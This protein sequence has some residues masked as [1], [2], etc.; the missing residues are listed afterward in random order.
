MRVRLPTQ[1]I[2]ILVL[3]AAGCASERRYPPPDPSEAE[4]LVEVGPVPG[5]ESRI[6]QASAVDVA[7]RPRDIL[8]LSGGGMYGA[9]PAGVLKGWAASGK[10]PRFDVVTGVSTGALIAVFAFLGPEY[11]TIL[12]QGYTST[13]AR[14]LFSLRIPPAQ[15]WADSLADA[16][17][18]RR[19]I[20]S[21]ITQDVLQR[22]AEAHTEGRR[23]YVG[24]TD[25]DTKRLVVWDMGAIASGS[26]PRKLKLFRNVL[27]ASC[28]VPGLL[29]S[30]PIDIEVNGQLRTELHVDGGVSASLFLPPSV[31]GMGKREAGPPVAD[32]N[33]YIIVA[34][35][36]RMD[37]KPV[38][39]R[40]THVT[41]ESLCVLLQACMEGDLLR[42]YML[43]RQ[44]GAVY[45]LTAVPE[46]MPLDS[47]W[48]ALDTA[49]LKRVFAAG[50][51]FAAG[52]GTWRTAPPDLPPADR[53]PPRT[54]V[55]FVTGP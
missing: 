14:D 48:M 18:L 49:A 20:R 39:R 50:Y 21:E 17:P 34:G 28:A 55:R 8:V 37:R 10:R 6:R 38:E 11:D 9:Y 26:D 1:T 41:E 4:R 12:E 36:L 46:Q 23:L 32:A 7:R 13:T 24:T 29:P 45:Q 2:L 5:D 16:Q 43:A 54:G 15:L 27:L 25:L 42:L 35:K 22:V 47:N 51:D 33:L 52:G 44:A 3:L 53:P 31:L 30:V 40:L 19:R